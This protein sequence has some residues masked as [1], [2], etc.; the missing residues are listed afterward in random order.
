M[1]YN[2]TLLSLYIGSNILFLN[3]LVEDSLALMAIV[4]QAISFIL[5]VHNVRSWWE[6]NRFIIWFVG[7]IIFDAM[8]FGLANFR[9]GLAGGGEA[10]MLYFFAIPYAILI[11]IISLIDTVIFKKKNNIL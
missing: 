1:I 4:V 11:N 2:L 8:I 6:G 3:S 5:L 10:G 7:V 9:V